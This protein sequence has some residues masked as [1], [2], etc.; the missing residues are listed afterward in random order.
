MKFLANHAGK[1]VASFG[2]K[3]VAVDITLTKLRKK[4]SSRK[5]SDKIQ[6]TLVPKGY[7]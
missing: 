1:W 7:I 4:V 3:V 2:D 6:Y 5:E